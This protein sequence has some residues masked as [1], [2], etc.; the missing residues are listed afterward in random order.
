MKRGFTLIELLIVIAIIGI[1]ASIVLV[2]VDAS[3]R[4][5]RVKSAM[6]SLQGTLPVI[7]ICNDANDPVLPQVAGGLICATAVGSFWP[8]LPTGYAYV[9]GATFDLAC[10]FDVSTSGDSSTDIRCQCLT[11]ACDLL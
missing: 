2:S 8:Q 5:A 9:A 3:R 1:L 4:S 7:I 10:S 11:Q 6:T